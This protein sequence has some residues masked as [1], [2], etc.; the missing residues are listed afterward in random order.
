MD[1][2]T[3]NASVESK[4]VSLTSTIVS[5]IKLT[6]SESPLVITLANI[7]PPSSLSAAI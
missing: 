1:D 5:I 3:S 6:L 4:T 2:K 7:A